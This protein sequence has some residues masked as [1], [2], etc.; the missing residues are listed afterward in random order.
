MN[1]SLSIRSFTGE[2]IED[3]VALSPL[4]REPVLR[5]FQRILGP[6]IYHLVYPDLR[7]TQLDLVRT[8]CP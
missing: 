2:D 7:K 1:E 6:R 8:I 5:S 3:I 4:A